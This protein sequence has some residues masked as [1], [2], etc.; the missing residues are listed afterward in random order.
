[1]SQLQHSGLLQQHRPQL[2]SVSLST[3]TKVI[4]FQEQWAELP[5]CSH[6]SV[7]VHQ[8]HTVRESYSR[9]HRSLSMEPKWLL[10]ES[11]VCSEAHAW[12]LAPEAGE[13]VPDWSVWRFSKVDS[14]D[15]ADHCHIR[16]S[17]QKGTAKDTA[18]SGFQESCDC[19]P[20]SPTQCGSPG[21]ERVR[22]Y[23]QFSGV[24]FLPFKP[25]SKYRLYYLKYNLFYPH[26]TFPILFASNITFLI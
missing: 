26:K 12:L 1:M 2:I 22:P 21:E 18:F 8:L 5:A 10:K 19:H 6:L 9:K 25:V 15:V 23:V 13:V 11:S 7:Q 20:L 4:P 3:Q 16:C 14:P 17:Q 24:L